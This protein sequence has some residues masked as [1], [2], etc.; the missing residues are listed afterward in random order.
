MQRTL[1]LRIESKANGAYIVSREEEVADRKSTD[2]R[3]ATS[4]GRQKAVVEVKIADNGWSLNDLE[5]ALR[6][7]LV[8]Q[9]LRHSNCRA[10]CLLL[11]YH[12]RK[13][14]WIHPETK[15]R[16]GFRQIVEYLREKARKIEKEKAHNVR[17]VVFGLDLTNP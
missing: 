16:L 13:K 12:G 1:A 14:Y 9:Y 10:G 2:I 11:T 17:I 7:Q 8:R 3:L 4:D 5:H 6:E 15:R